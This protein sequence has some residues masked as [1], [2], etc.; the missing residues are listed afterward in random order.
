MQQL[1][2]TI[3]SRSS[4]KA[5]RAHI[6]ACLAEA[7]ESVSRFA[8]LIFSRELVIWQYSFLFARLQYSTSDPDTH[9]ITHQSNTIHTIRALAQKNSDSELVELSYLLEITHAFQFNVST[10]NVEQFLVLAAQASSQN[11]FRENQLQLSLM[12]MLLHVLYLVKCGNVPT[13][14][15][16]LREYHQLMDTRGTNEDLWHPEGRFDL[17]ACNGTQ[18]LYFEWLTHS[19]SFVFGYILSG[20]AHLPDCSGP[21]SRK[22][23]LEGARVADSILSINDGS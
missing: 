8:L 2:A 4:F 10:I 14:L 18:R 13:A 11:P 23:F 1:Q 6:N 19:E 12:R 9:E 5:T 17:L 7:Q 22:F 15:A 20:M 16:K 3:L 21:K